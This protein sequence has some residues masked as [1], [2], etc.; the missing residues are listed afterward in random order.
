LRDAAIDQRP[1]SRRIRQWV[2]SCRLSH[3]GSGMA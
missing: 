2:L 3:S 1:G